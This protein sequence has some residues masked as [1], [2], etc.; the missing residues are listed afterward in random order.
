M[1][2][3]GMDFKNYKKKS[4]FKDWALCQLK[5]WSLKISKLKLP[6]NT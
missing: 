2:I 5:D 3:E 1:S 4:I 6:P